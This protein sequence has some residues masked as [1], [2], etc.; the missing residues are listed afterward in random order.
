MT[1]SG[2]PKRRASPSGCANSRTWPASAIT[3]HADWTGNPI[4]RARI[5]IAPREAGFHAW[6]LAS[7]LAG[8]TPSIVVRDDLVERQE[9]YLD[10]CNLTDA[11]AAAVAVAIREEVGLFRARGD[12]CRQSWS[13]VKRAREAAILSWTGNRDVAP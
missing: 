8:R 6:E 5:T 7:R 13:D 2:G 9:L 4:T 12:G 1:P 3:S 11:E 10:P